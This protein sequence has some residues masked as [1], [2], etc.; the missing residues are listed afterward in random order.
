MNILKANY[1]LLFT[2]ILLLAFKTSYGQ[3]PDLAKALYRLSPEDSAGI[4]SL[5][6]NGVQVNKGKTIAWFPKDSLSVKRMNE[7]VDTINLGIAAAE[8][9]IGAPLAWQHHK[10]EE[11]Y[12]YFFRTDSFI[13]RSHGGFIS[14]RFPLVRQGH[15][16]W[17]HEVM[18]EMLEAK[19]ND[20]IPGS[21]WR[22]NMPHWLVEGLPEYIAREVYQQFGWAYFDLSRKVIIDM[23]SACKEDLN[24][25]NGKYALSYIGKRGRL[26][27]L[28]TQGNREKYAFAFYHCS[29]SFTKYLVEQKGLTTVLNSFAASPYVQQAFEKSTNSSIEILKKSWLNKLQVE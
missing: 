12:T 24:N 11:A 15:A 17:L 19:A 8:K 13:S 5:L 14:I 3:L 22:E 23:D 26:G 27:D 4:T 16:P 25:E 29:C 18:H 1:L 7:F 9:F 6:N 2:P 28:A 20:S 21:A 10:K